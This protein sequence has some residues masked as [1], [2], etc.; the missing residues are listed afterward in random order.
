MEFY[1]L[2]GIYARYLIYDNEQKRQEI[3]S[4]ELQRGI[5]LANIHTYKSRF[6]QKGWLEWAHST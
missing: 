1:S 6:A 5:Q 2:S 4:Q 3:Y